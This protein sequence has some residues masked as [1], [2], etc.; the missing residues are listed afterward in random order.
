ADVNNR[1]NIAGAG[2][3]LAQRVM[4]CGDTGHILLSKHVAE[5]LEHYRSWQTYLH[6]L[7]P[8]EVKHGMRVGI[9]NFY[10]DQFG[11]PALPEKIK[12]A[13][14]RTRPSAD[15][16]NGASGARQHALIVALVVMSALI[17]AAILYERLGARR[18]PNS[19]VSTLASLA[20]L[21]LKNLS[22]D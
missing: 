19:S 2:I 11:N 17:A 3:N 5:D 7:G 13:R 21:P 14:E 20:V 18:S 12:T 15:E 4:D 9:V 16:V 6:D 8:V 22:G 10:G 1:S